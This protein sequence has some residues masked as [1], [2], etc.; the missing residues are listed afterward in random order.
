L[1]SV[2]GGKDWL[3]VSTDGIFDGSGAAGASVLPSRGATHLQ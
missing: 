1:I 3:V 2:D